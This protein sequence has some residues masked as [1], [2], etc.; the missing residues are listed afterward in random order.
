MNVIKNS[1]LSRK[2]H[3]SISFKQ[4]ALRMDTIFVLGLKLR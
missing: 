4:C 1:I 2:I 3:S